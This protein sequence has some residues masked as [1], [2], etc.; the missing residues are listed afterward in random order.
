VPNKLAA[1]PQVTWAGASI[2]WRC[3]SNSVL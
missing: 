2:E 3:G 1:G